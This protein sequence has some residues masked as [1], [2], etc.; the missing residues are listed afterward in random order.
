[1]QQLNSIVNGF[2]MAVGV[3]LAYVLFHALGVSAGV[4]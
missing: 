3:G 4:C 2:L 1:M